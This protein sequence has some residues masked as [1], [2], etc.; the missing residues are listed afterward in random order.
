[1]RIKFWNG[2]MVGLRKKIE[3]KT[4]KIKIW[5]IVNFCLICWQVLNQ[6]QLIKR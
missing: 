5:Q 3:F 2:Q 1:M 4:L 6:E